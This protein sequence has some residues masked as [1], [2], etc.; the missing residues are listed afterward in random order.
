MADA[1]RDPTLYSGGTPSNAMKGPEPTSNVWEARKPII[2][3]V[4][5]RY[6]FLSTKKGKAAIIGG[7]LLIIG[8]GLCGLIALRNRGG[9]SNNGGDDQ[10]IADDVYFFGES[11]SIYP[12]RELPWFLV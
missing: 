8:G 2:Y 10:P 11:P 5:D 4:R 7:I 9:G 1:P 3:R 6:P 12:S